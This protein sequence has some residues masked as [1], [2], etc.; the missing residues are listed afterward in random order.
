VTER[1]ILKAGVQPWADLWQTMRRSCEKEWAMVYPQY[2]VSQ[3]IGHSITV[4][5]RHYVNAVPDELFD[6]ASE[7]DAEAAHNAAQF[8]AARGR[9]EPHDA[10]ADTTEPAFFGHQRGY[11]GRCED[12]KRVSEGIRTP[13]PFKKTRGK[14][15]IPN[16]AQRQA[17]RVLH[18]QPRS[19]PNLP[20]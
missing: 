10:R 4:S 7:V 9:T 1:I 13:D 20:N 14:W 18:R 12:E 8:P 6:R 11:A 3:W 17:Q 2:A 16:R 5:G 19:T 15:T